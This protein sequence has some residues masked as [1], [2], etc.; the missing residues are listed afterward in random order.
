MARERTREEV[1]Q[2]IIRY[3]KVSR[4]ELL[5]ADSIDD[6]MEPMLVIEVIFELEEK[7]GMEVDDEEVLKV[8]TIEDLIACVLQRLDAAA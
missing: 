1:L 2:T 4:D 8:E 3:S 7:F 5:A 6:L